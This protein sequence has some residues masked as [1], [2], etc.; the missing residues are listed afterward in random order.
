M[1]TKAIVPVHFTGQMCDM[2][3]I[4]DVA[5]RR[6][7]F[8]VEDAAQAFG[9]SQDGGMC[10]S[11]GELSCF[12]MNPMK[13][14]AAYGEAGIV[15]TDDDALRDRLQSLRNNG[16]VDKQDCHWPSL[17]SRLD[18]VQAAMLLVNLKRLPERIAVRRAIAHAYTE[19]LKEVVQCPVERPGN[20]HTY[21]AYSVL[22]ERR[23]ALMTHLAL[24]G[25]ET[26]VQ[27]SLPLPRQTAYRDR[28][29]PSTPVADWAA[30]R[31]LCLPNQED[32]TMEQVAYV[33]GHI[34][35]FYAS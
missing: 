33:C 21:Y 16:T 14:L 9:S 5:R 20:L 11:L 3:W 15:L 6:G 23:D 30:Q 32:L 22:A 24:K 27:H 35:E 31:I 28:V 7:L 25:V 19:R 8:V 29:H 2:R 12:S 1:R 10:G 18:T 17:N 4:L 34:R 13:V 26:Q